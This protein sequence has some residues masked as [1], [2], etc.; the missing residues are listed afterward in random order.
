MYQR[1]SDC[2]FGYTR[3]CH[4]TCGPECVIG[5]VSTLSLPFYHRVAGTGEKT[6]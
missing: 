4:L 3:R 6:P 5:I 1:I 2:P